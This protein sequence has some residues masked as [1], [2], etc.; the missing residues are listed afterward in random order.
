MPITQIPPTPTLPLEG[1]GEGGGEFGSFE[2][3]MWSLF[4]LTDVGRDLEFVIWDL[5]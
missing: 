5:D 1:E 4:G 3:R 2:I